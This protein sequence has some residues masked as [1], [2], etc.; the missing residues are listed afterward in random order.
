MTWSHHY[1]DNF[2]ILPINFSLITYSL[3][4]PSF[5]Y[6]LSASFPRSLPNTTTFHII[7]YLHTSISSYLHLPYISPFAC[8]CHISICHISTSPF[9]ISFHCHIEM[10]CCE[11]KCKKALSV[12][13][14]NCNRGIQLPLPWYAG[15]P[16][17]SFTYMF[18]K[19][20][21][22]V[23]EKYSKKRRN[24]DFRD[25]E[26][27]RILALCSAANKA[28][29]ALN[30]LLFSKIFSYLWRRRKILIFPYVLRERFGKAASWKFWSGKDYWSLKLNSK[31]SSS[32]KL[33]TLNK[34]D[35]QLP[36]QVGTKYHSFPLFQQFLTKF[37]KAGISRNDFPKL[38]SLPLS[39]LE[40][41][42]IQKLQKITN[43]F[44]RCHNLGGWA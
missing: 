24:P 22:E 27:L 36:I 35:I 1:Q 41:I 5:N 20:L 34:E 17:F 26:E 28:L 33:E 39:L 3:F 15:Y 13:R 37:G 30:C 4:L 40:Q 9:A 16:T 10:T 38:Y 44:E 25:W 29:N 18:V 19:I 21:S 7:I 6:L 42:H 23:L 12:W 31:A 43:K 11:W 8:N 14:R 2:H 32:S